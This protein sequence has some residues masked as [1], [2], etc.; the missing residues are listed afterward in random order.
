MAAPKQLSPDQTTAQKHY[1]ICSI[2]L[3]QPRSTSP[4]AAQP[5]R[6]GKVM[7]KS[8][9]QPQSDKTPSGGCERTAQNSHLRPPTSTANTPLVP[10]CFRLLNISY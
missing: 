4:M 9:Q 6:R 7:S 5:Y 8:L 3:H 2:Q 1:V 10:S